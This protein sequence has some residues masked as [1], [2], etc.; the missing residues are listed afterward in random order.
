MK[1]LA[2]VGPTG[3]G[4]TG[5][6]VELAKLI[7]AEIISAD[8]RLVYQ[9]FDIGTAKPTIEERCGIPHHLVDIV[10]PYDEFSV[11]MYKKLVEESI[12]EITSRNKNIIIVGGTGLYVRAVLDGLSIPKVHAD[13]AFREEMRNFAINN[14]SDALHQKLA[15]VDPV[16]AQEIHPN[17]LIKIIRALEVYKVLNIPMSQAKSVEKPPYETIYV[18][19]TAENRDYLYDRTNRRVDMM[20]ESGLV[21]EVENLIKK[22]GKTLSL[23]KTLGYKEISDYLDGTISLEKAIYLIKKNTRNFAKR[24]LTWFRA[25]KNINWFDIET[26]TQQEIISKVIELYNV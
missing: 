20:L 24:Q 1:I 5:L 10:T 13:E 15:E 7:D 14:G 6:S 23:L 16:S 8:S 3:S 21:T 2:I 25:N 18:G 12:E 26:Q 11:S 17:N 22:Y 4:K 19:L 9:E